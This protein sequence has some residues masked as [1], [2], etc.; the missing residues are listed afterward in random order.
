MAHQPAFLARILREDTHS[1]IDTLQVE[2]EPLRDHIHQM[3][4]KL[5]RTHEHYFLGALDDDK[6]GRDESKPFILYISDKEDPA[7]VRT[8]L[9]EAKAR[10]IAKIESGEITGITQ[11]TLPEIEIRALPPKGQE[12]DIPKDQ[13]GLLYL[14]H[15]YVVPGVRFNEMYNWDSAFVARGLLQDEQFDKAKDL[16]DNMLYQIEHYGTILNGNRSYYL[17][18]EK[19]RSQPPLL[20]AKVL[21]VY[22]NFDQLENGHVE[23]KTEW[24]KRAAKLAE[25]Y[26]Q[27]WVTPP[28]LNEESGLSMYNTNHGTPG[29]EVVYSEPEHYVEAY[30]RLVAM[31]ESTRNTSLPMSE[32]DYQTRKDMY[33]VE[34][35]LEI[36]G[37][38]NPSG[39]SDKF[40][41][42]DWAMRESGLDPS[43]RFGFFNAD[44]INML[45][46][47]LN[48][49]RQKMEAEIGAVYGILAETEPE[50][51]E[52][53]V[54]RDTWTAKS[55]DTA[56][57]MREWLWDKGEMAPDGE[58][59]RAPLFRDRNMNHELLEKFDIPPFRDYDF[60]TDFFPMWTGIATEQQ[61][62]HIVR[63]SLPVLATEHGIQTSTR[64]S[65]SQW[66]APFMWAPLQVVVMEAL[67]KY[68][69]YEEAIEI[70]K[71]FL[72][73]VKGEFEKEGHVFEKYEAIEGTS[74][75]G[76]YVDKGYAT[77]DVGFAWTNSAVLEISVALDRLQ[78]KTRGEELEEPEIPTTQNVKTK[79]QASPQK[80][81][82]V[83]FP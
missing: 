49:L 30:K 83:S 66:D 47:D 44:V 42:G 77:N 13:H 36:D 21:A 58:I 82:G 24:L 11:D 70:G 41:R 16:V 51:A 54:K 32:L 71:N 59:T 78:K 18:T 34:Q 67:E 8:E 5:T 48:S 50:V 57:R 38:G 80:D 40:Y 64:H 27:H 7:R 12:V 9:D 74:K 23:D 65:G 63:N 60:A 53:Q 3:W 46:V 14:P 76:Q 43:R 25:D 37:N 31:Y 19:S 4:G 35:Y 20:T 68:N 2:L 28:H 10:V 55:Q 22:N 52:W 81:S 33:Y 45:P 75:T 15:S 39:L 26:H 79:G 73:T 29:A 61:A 17:D 69:Y 1:E 62:E 6:I 56:D 72:Q